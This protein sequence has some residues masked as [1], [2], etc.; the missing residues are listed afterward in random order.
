MSSFL[1]GF[2]TASA[3]VILLHYFN[4]CD[5]NGITISTTTQIVLQNYSKFTNI[6]YLYMESF[7]DYVDLWSLFQIQNR[8]YTVYSLLLSVLLL[9]I[10]SLSM[11]IKLFIKPKS[12]QNNVYLIGIATYDPPKSCEINSDTFKAL[13]RRE[14]KFTQESIDFMDRLLDRTGL[15]Q[16]TSFPETL[17]EVPQRSDM[18]ASREEAETEL[19]STI[20]DLLKKTNINP[21]DIDILVLNCSIFVP[22]PSLTSMIVNHYK[23]KEN[24]Q[25]YNLGG[26]G[27]SA[28]VISIHLAKDLLKVYKNSTALVVSTEILT[29]C[30]YT[31][32]DKAFLL[33]NTLFRCGAS[34]VLLSNKESDRR[35]AQFQLLHSVRIHTGADD[36][37]YQ[38][39]FLDN[40]DAGERGVRLSKALVKCAGVALTRNLT[41]LAPKI[42]PLSEKINYA[43]NMI[44][45][46]WLKRKI[47]A[48]VPNF[49]KAIDHFCIHTGGRAVLEGVQQS[50]Q[51]SDDLIA[52]SKAILN[53]RGNTSSSSIWYEMQYLLDNKLVRRNQTVLQMGFG[54]GFKCNSAVWKAL[55]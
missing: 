53:C 25:S 13:T 22:T 55:K 24:I 20:D 48:Y 38:A 11:V 51:L 47:P 27:C 15:G 31:G 18:K 16:T 6:L 9:C 3:I 2:A 7:L 52:P 45:R 30:W 36:E 17:L 49:K 12:T 10:A 43:L 21:K 50:L 41:T 39:I 37:S 4:V 44:Q 1:Q 19:F 23:M 8:V 28:G 34:A 32:N 14:K 46:K 29:P 54:S 40:D 5:G 33:Q 26:M 42:L 35:R